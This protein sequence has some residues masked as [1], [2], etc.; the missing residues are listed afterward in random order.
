M[1]YGLQVTTTEGLVI[2]DSLLTSQVIAI[3]NISGVS[4]SIT[5]TEF[6]SNIGFVFMKKNNPSGGWSILPRFTFNNVSKVFDWFP[7]S[8]ARAS[9]T[10]SDNT[11]IFMRVL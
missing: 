8:A 5:V 9:L 4:G 11:V 10:S 1:P 2:T 3:E 7:E 6:D